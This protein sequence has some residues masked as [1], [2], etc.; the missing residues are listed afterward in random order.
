MEGVKTYTGMDVASARAAATIETKD[1]VAS[2][3]GEISI[4]CSAINELVRRVHNEVAE[5]DDKISPVLTQVFPEDANLCM[6]TTDTN[7]G[8]RLADIK[9]GVETVLSYVRALKARVNI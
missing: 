3:E 1:R 9:Y 4:L 5:L 2:D 6:A 8:A 7:I